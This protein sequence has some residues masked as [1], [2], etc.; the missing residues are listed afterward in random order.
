MTTDSYVS[1]ELMF[2]ARAIHRHGIAVICVGSGTCSVPRCR[3]EPEIP[4]WSYTV[5]FAER[6]NP[7]VVTFGLH[8]SDAITLSNL[9]RH[10]ELNGHDVR[11][12]DELVLLGRPVRFVSVPTEWA[13]SEENPMGAWYRHYGVGRP[14]L[15]PPE[16]VQ[17]VWSDERARFP[18]DPSCD[19]VVAAA[20]PHGV[21]LA[22]PAW[23]VE[24]DRRL[25]AR[26]IA[27]ARMRR[28][29]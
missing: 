27:T 26:M 18:D 19:P 4:T 15:R 5:G 2:I 9:L 23:C 8:P 21:A 24:P 22:S 6:D 17:L 29:T 11:P 10:H 12:G 13:S 16:V 14:E 28:F 25:R 1:D 20:Q 3:C 7:E